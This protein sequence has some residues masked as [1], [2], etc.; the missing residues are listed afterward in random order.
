MTTESDG[1]GSLRDD[2][3]ARSEE[4]PAAVLT[5]WEAT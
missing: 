5:G 3:A 1:Y 4:V 2:G